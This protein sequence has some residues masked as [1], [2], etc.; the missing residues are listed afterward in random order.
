[1]NKP[2][3]LG[4]YKDL[5]P[6]NI[7]NIYCNTYWGNHQYTREEDK[8]ELYKLIK[9][10][11]IL[12]DLFNIKK[13]TTNIPKKYYKNIMVIDYKEYEKYKNSKTN[14]DFA[15]KYNFK[16]SNYT[17]RHDLEYFNDYSNFTWSRDHT[18]Y[19]ITKFNQ[20]VSIFSTHTN[21]YELECIIKSGYQL[22]E[23]I[24][25]ES[26]KTFIKTINRY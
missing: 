21:D 22:V 23:P 20:I 19:Y 24:Y 8:E 12:V 25:H 2:K 1:M 5:L 6:K 14:I 16:P 4:Y 17:K 15:K 26:Q 11:E 10:R 18:E 9:N 13:R 7:Y 3:A